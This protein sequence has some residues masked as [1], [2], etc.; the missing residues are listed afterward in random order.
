[1]RIFSSLMPLGLLLAFLGLLNGVC[2][3]AALAQSVRKGKRGDELQDRIPAVSGP[4]FLKAGRHELSPL[5]S[6]SLA[7]AFRQKLGGG[8]IYTWHL[9]EHFGLS[10]RGAYTV[11]ERDA[12]AVQVCPT[13]DSCKGPDNATLDRLPGNLTLLAT[14]SGEVSPL[15]GKLNIIAEK[16][17]H[18]DIF[19]SVGVGVVGYRSS[20]GSGSSIGLAVPLAVGQRF[21]VSEWFALRL[22]LSDLLYTQVDVGG[23]RHLRGQIGFTLGFSFFFPTHFDARSVR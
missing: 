17:L 10:L 6:L 11:F 19:A 2:P 18:F 15:Y 9:E 4:L 7:D 14:A 16:V 13:Q 3:T 1:M 23:D 5:L 21:F 12:G 20:G 8:L 22:E